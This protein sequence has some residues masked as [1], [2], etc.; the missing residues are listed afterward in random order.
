MRSAYLSVFEFRLSGALVASSMSRSAINQLLGAGRRRIRRRSANRFPLVV[1]CRSEQT[2]VFVI[3]CLS[4]LEICLPTVCLRV[5]FRLS[6]CLTSR[7]YAL[8]AYLL[9]SYSPAACFN[10]HFRDTVGSGTVVQG[11][12]CLTWMGVGPSRCVSLRAHLL[13]CSYCHCS[14]T[15]LSCGEYMFD[16]H[17]W[18]L[19][20]MVVGFADVGP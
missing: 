7:P 16:A 1:L 14:L 3:T 10:T 11:M 5:C 9:S 20:W 2:P 4:L 8:I 12:S 15:R 6:A 17:F 13:K 19:V 18:L